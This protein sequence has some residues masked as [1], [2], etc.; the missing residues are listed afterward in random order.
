MAISSISIQNK[1][2]N[3]TA[4]NFRNQFKNGS[5]ILVCRWNLVFRIHLWQGGRKLFKPISKQVNPR[6]TNTRDHVGKKKQFK[7]LKRFNNK[8][9]TLKAVKINLIWL[10]FLSSLENSIWKRKLR[11]LTIYPVTIPHLFCMFF[12]LFAHTPIAEPIDSQWN[13]NRKGIMFV[14]TLNCWARSSDQQSMEHGAKH[15]WR[16]WHLANCKFVVSAL[17]KINTSKY[18]KPWLQWMDSIYRCFY[19]RELVQFFKVFFLMTF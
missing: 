4:V 15:V 2:I 18:Q 13:I 11:Y 8:K 3:S 16:Q 14:D 10:M 17:T 5:K 7:V 6:F 9:L 12:E 19:Y 1:L